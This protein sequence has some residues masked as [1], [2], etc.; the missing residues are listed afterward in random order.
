[1]V[2]ATVH[3]R[4]VASRALYM[5]RYRIRLVRRD[6]WYVAELNQERSGR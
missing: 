1:V 3:A 5:L 2:L 6:R 4:D